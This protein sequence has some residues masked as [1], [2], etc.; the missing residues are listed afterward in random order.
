[1]AFLTLGRIVHYRHERHGWIAALVVASTEENDTAILEL[2][3]WPG[4]A[5]VV[6]RFV[7]VSRSEAGPVGNAGSWRWPP[8]E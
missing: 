4:A 3:P 1:L 8:R 5:T 2:H 7:T 6:D